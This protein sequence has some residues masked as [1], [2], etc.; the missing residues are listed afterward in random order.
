MNNNPKMKNRLFV[1]NNIYNLL[2]KNSFLTTN[3]VYNE[4]IVLRV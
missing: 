4:E 3:T 2:N 1:T